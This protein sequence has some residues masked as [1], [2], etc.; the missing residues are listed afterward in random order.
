[1]EASQLARFPPEV[2][3][4][5]SSYLTFQELLTCGTELRGNWTGGVQ[6]ELGRRGIRGLSATSVSQVIHEQNPKSES[7]FK[8]SF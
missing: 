5:I 7:I 6:L 8:L 2:L 1:M 3:A 4:H